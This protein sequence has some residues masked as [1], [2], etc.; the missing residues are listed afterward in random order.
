MKMLKTVF[1]LLVLALASQMMT[2]Q[3]KGVISI[4]SNPTGTT[5][6][7]DKIS[8]IMKEKGIWELGWSFHA[9]GAAQPAGLFGLGFYTTREAYEKRSEAT[10]PVFE[11][12]GI[13]P[14]VQVCEIYNSFLGTIPATKPA[15]GIVVHFNSGSMTTAQ[16]DQ[17][18]VELQTAKAFPPAGQIAH[19]CY[20]TTDGLKVIDVWESAETFNAFGQI[21]MPIMQKLGI[22]SGQP[23]VYSLYNYMKTSN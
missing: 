19:F 4:T 9:M 21:L 13:K 17:I 18:L 16:Y 1:A 22:N 7:Y 15:A 2:A 20:Q 3:S 23:A 6:D 10:K 11:A 8:G 12:A 14:N 5:A